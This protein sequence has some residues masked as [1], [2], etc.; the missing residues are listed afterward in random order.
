[1]FKG[2]FARESVEIMTKEEIDI[3]IALGILKGWEWSCEIWDPK[4]KVNHA[5]S[6]MRSEEFP[7][8]SSVKKFMRERLT[9]GTGIS[10]PRP[11]IVKA[12]REKRLVW[13]IERIG[14][15]RR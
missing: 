15:I 11:E 3:Q 4:T 5:F 9:Y 10:M 13:V 2:R 8:R 14:I 6:Y 12:L 7:T 1:M